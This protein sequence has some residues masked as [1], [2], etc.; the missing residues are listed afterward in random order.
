VGS[1]AGQIEIA[2][3][4]PSWPEAFTAESMR[5]V[6]GVGGLI[7]RTEHIG[8]TSVPGLKA[9]PMIDLMAEAVDAIPDPML[10]PRLA[11]IGYLLRPDEFTDR[12]LFSR[13]SDQ[14]RTHNLHVVG[15]GRLDKANEV[16]FRDRLRADPEVA[17]R[18]AVLK[19]ELATRTWERFAYSRAKTEFV[20]EVVDEERAKLGLAPVDIWSI[21]GPKRREAWIRS[22]EPVPLP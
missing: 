7:Q 4:D 9:K 21:L 11:R 13:G 8:S 20:V 6:A 16:L 5:V 2:D 22:G 1:S 3:Y 10:V 18:Y 17:S 19:G 12:L 14:A 15:A